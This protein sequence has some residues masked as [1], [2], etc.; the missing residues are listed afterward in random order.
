SWLATVQDSRVIM[1][2][3]VP[4]LPAVIGQGGANFK[5]IQE[6]H[7]VEIDVRKPGDGASPGTGYTLTVWGIDASALEAARGEILHIISANTKHGVAVAIDPA[8]VPY[9]V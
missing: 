2:V 8:M 5:R 9:L 7:R 6:A 4:V 1:L 3:P